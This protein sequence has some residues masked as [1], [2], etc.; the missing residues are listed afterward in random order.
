[1]NYENVYEEKKLLRSK[2]RKLLK[3][4]YS[5]LKNIQA[6]GNS[7][8]QK[9]ILSEEFINS[10]LIFSYI[11]YG[12]EIDPSFLVEIAWKNG[13]TVCVPRVVPD[14]NLMDF[15][16]LDS[17]LSLQNQLESGAFGILEPK[18]T[19]KKVFT[20]SS[21]RDKKIFMV[22]PGLAFSKD[23][24]RL[25]KGK[26]FYDLYLPRLLKTGCSLFTA[27]FAYCEQIVENIPVEKTDFFL[28]RIFTP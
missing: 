3:E 2:M 18:L 1:M 17:K 16:F 5:D 20:D 19:L 12:F 22:V 11:P 26:G 13:K 4:R 15:Y 28:D 7:A 10:D 21:I 25:G 14:S 6:A 8:A 24:A 9:I 23:G 27:G